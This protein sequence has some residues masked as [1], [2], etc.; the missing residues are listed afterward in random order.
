[1]PEPLRIPKEY[2]DRAEVIRPNSVKAPDPAE[3]N[4]DGL[5]V[6]ITL[7]AQEIGA[8]YAARATPYAFNQH[9][10][11]K[12]KAAGAPVEGVLELKMSHGQVFK[13]KDDLYNRPGAFTYMW[14]NDQYAK[15]LSEGGGEA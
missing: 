8:L 6:V 13:M 5:P 7:D 9:L 12:F 3:L 4:R 11:E 15:A 10:L 1:M 2:L 14:V